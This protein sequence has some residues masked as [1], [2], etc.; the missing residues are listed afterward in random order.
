MK[1]IKE[2][3][4]PNFTQEKQNISF[5]LNALTINKRVSFLRQ[6]RFQYAETIICVSSKVIYDTG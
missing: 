5:H 6:E 4:E 1:G 3:E 2:N